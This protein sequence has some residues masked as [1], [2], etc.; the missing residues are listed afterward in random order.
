MPEWRK[1]ACQGQTRVPK[2]SPRRP[3]NRL[4]R[5]GI[6]TRGW[7]RIGPGEA[8]EAD[9]DKIVSAASGTFG[10]RYRQSGTFDLG[11]KPHEGRDGV[12]RSGCHPP[13]TPPAPRDQA[14]RSAVAPQG[15]LEP[16]GASGKAPGV[17]VGGCEHTGR[18]G[19]LA[20]PPGVLAT[21]ERLYTRETPERRYFFTSMHWIRLYLLFRCIHSRPDLSDTAE[22]QEHLYPE[23]K[24][25]NICV[26]AFSRVHG[27]SV[28]PDSQESGSAARGDA[29]RSLGE[30]SCRGRENSAPVPRS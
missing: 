9:S 15:T 1:T 17:T 21:A 13:S 26:F 8:T 2:L 30:P 12:T 25:R 4:L 20:G 24:S 6:R 14:C 10:H 18:G 27:V 28:P 3:R 11:V 22:Q 5:G 23:P 7:S 29:Q 16:L 19:C